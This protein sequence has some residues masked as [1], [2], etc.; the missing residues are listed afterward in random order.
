MSSEST[1]RKLAICFAAGAVGVLAVLAPLKAMATPSPATHTVALGI[2]VS[3]DDNAADL[4]DYTSNAGRSPKLVMWFQSWSEPLYYS[5][6][7]PPVDAAGAIP[8]I[9]WDPAN[10]S[11]G[12][13]LA[14]IT[15]GQYDS[16]IDSSAQLAKNYGKPL[17]IRFAHEMNLGSSAWGPGNTGNT[18][19]EFVAAWRYVVTR[20]AADGATNVQ[21]VWSP[22]VSCG[23]SCPFDAFF[24]GDAYVNYVALDGYNYSSVDGVPWMSFSQI[25]A[26][27]YDDITALSSRPLMIAE[28]ASADAGGDKAAW[29]RQSFLTDIPTSFTRIVAVAWFER[30]KET[31]WQVNSTAA[32]LAAWREVVD[33]PIYSATLA[34]AGSPVPTPSTT[35]TPLASE[36]PSPTASPAPTASTSTAPTA[37]PTPTTNPTTVPTPTTPAVTPIAPVQLGEISFSK[38]DHHPRRH[39]RLNDEYVTVQNVSAQRL[40]VEGWWLTDQRGHR[41]SFPAVSIAPHHELVVHTGKGRDHGH[42]LYWQRNKLVWRYADRAR[43]FDRGGRPIQTC[44]WH[45]VQ[46]DATNCGQS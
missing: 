27:S 10:A 26:S 2:D 45:G 22:N 5:S 6:Q 34:T 46:H 4:S 29:I 13:P 7:L 32:S 20:F 23:G 12:I 38:A 8:M 36:S 24:P 18:P 9:T 3:G 30:T 37:T 17:L 40:S 19:A 25:F 33:S 21:W 41:F 14:A 44:T 39:D 11:G 28:T 43:L 16:Y 35:P 1:G 42:A 31:D 15:S